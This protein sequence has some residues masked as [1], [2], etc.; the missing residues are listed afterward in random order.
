MFTCTM[1]TTTAFQDRQS[2]LSI[3]GKENSEEDVLNSFLESVRPS[4]ENNFM[5]QYLSCAQLMFRVG[6]TLIVHGGVNNDSFG[7][8]PGDSEIRESADDWEKDLNAWCSA[9]VDDFVKQPTWKT[10]P[11]PETGKGER[12]GDGLMDYGVPG[13]NNGKTV[14]YS[15][16]LN[17]GNAA[18]IPAETANYLKKN[19]I[20]RV[21]VGH[22]PHGDCPTV[23]NNGEVQ[24][25]TA[26]TSYSDMSTPDNRG[27]AVSE[28]LIHDNETV[29]VHGI[30]K[31]NSAIE[32]SLACPTK[33]LD[34]CDD[35]VGK[36]LQDDWWVKSKLKEVNSDGKLYLI[37]KGEGYKLDTQLLSAEETKAKL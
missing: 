16:Y 25:I 31:D 3:L 4:G 14:V 32:Y 10:L 29:E 12:G 28:I 6:S 33:P 34:F 21:I 27:C 13:G 36:K 23:I 8:V 26:D 22:Q 24:V 2:E 7:T 19:G 37:A 15:N 30:L 17:N 1:G 5:L 20:F 11:D 35:L 18:D 9:Q